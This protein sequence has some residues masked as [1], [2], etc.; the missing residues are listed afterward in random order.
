MPWCGRCRTALTP[1]TG[2]AGWGG[3]CRGRRLGGCRARCRAAGRRSPHATC[4][5]AHTPPAPRLPA[6]PCS[7][8]C[9]PMALAEVPLRQRVK[10]IT[11]ATGEVG[12]RR[13]WAPASGAAP[14]PSSRAP[15]PP[16]APF[17]SCADQHGY[18]IYFSRG[19]LPAN[20]DGEVRCATVPAVPAAPA[21][22]SPPGSPRRR[23]STHLLPYPR[24]P[25][26]A[27]CT[28]RPY[29]TPFHD[30]PYLLHL[31]L[32]CY[33]RAFLRTYCAMPPTPLQVG[34]GMVG[35]GGR[36]VVQRGA[37]PAACRQTVH[38]ALCCLPGCMRRHATSLALHTTLTPHHHTHHSKHSRHRPSAP[39]LLLLR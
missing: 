20:K 2:A 31:G 37:R 3:A 23:A 18:A 13:R 11:G 7:T 33:D 10:C 4:A 27:T 9:T 8:A 15:P 16:P 32:Q 25:P 19:A 1:S 24:P 21:A 30:R 5:A 38:C 12:L 28:R 35:Q 26:I 34:L 17:S 6:T 39:L 29:P 36:W 22:A 14:W